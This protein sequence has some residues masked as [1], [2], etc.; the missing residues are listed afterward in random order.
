VP[1][2]K[3][4]APEEAHRLIDEHI[5]AGAIMSAITALIVQRGATYRDALRTVRARHDRL[6]SLA[7]SR[8][9]T[10]AEE[11]WAA[12]PGSSRSARAPAA[13]PS[14]TD[15]ETTTHERPSAAA[16]VRVSG[17]R[18]GARRIVVD[19]EVYF[20]RVPRRSNHN[21][22]DLHE[23]VFALVQRE[24]GG[25]ELALHFP[26]PHPSEA[27]SPTPVLPSDVAEAIRTWRKTGAYPSPVLTRK[28]IFGTPRGE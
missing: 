2:R 17:R 26:Q 12:F 14:S 11:Y 16:N 18:K 24:E 8:F 23:S 21:Q 5:F 6:R 19:G 13:S 10:T 7:P 4:L 22:H 15:R 27:S 1:R 28:A 20:W 3:R 9:S 25:A